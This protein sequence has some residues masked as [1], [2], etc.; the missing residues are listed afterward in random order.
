MTIPVLKWLDEKGTHYQYLYVGNC[1]IHVAY[2]CKRKTFFSWN[3]QIPYTGI[4]KTYMPENEAKCLCEGL[5]SIFLSKAM[6]EP[7]DDIPF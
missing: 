6:E 5:V 7:C 4:F 1:P 2:I 3:V